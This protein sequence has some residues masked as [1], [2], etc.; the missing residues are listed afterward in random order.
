MG[1]IETVILLSLW[2]YQGEERKVE[3]WYHQDNIGACLK[4]KRYAEK[5]AGKTNKYTCSIEK[6]LMTV[7]Q[8]GVK[9]CDKIIKD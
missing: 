7:D 2:I 6:C 3:G 4:T 9:H 5:N 8:T 1:L